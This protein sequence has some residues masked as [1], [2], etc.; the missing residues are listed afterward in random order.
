MLHAKFHDNQLQFTYSLG[1][2]YHCYSL[3][4]IW[5]NFHPYTA[6]RWMRFWA[7][8]QHMQK[9]YHLTLCPYQEECPNC[10]RTM[11]VSFKWVTT[12]RGDLFFQIFLI[13]FFQITSLVSSIILWNKFLS[14]ECKS[15]G[16][17]KKISSWDVTFYTFWPMISTPQ[18]KK[19]A[20][21]PLQGRSKQHVGNLPP[22]VDGWKLLVSVVSSNLGR[23]DLYVGTLTRHHLHPSPSAHIARP[24]PVLLFSFFYYYYSCF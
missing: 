23:L 15:L 5:P 7:S 8:P 9:A 12:H 16:F 1:V 17:S 4:K 10:I 3:R 19:K 22:L 14:V 6:Y 13:F 18:K 21:I 2:N 24:L 11:R 20:L